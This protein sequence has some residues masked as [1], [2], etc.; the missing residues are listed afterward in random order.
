MC[1]YCSK[2]ETRH[3]E[4]ATIARIILNGQSQE[5]WSYEQQ[6]GNILRIILSHKQKGI[7][8]DHQLITSQPNTL[9]SYYS[10][11]DSITL[12]NNTLYKEWISPNLSTKNLL[13]LLPK[14]KIYTILS[15]AYDSPSAEH[16]G[17]NKTLARIRNRF[18]WPTY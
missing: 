13:I 12:I 17:I 14:H 8:P 3:N 6:Q 7:K 5:N 11:W 9:R 2:I 10:I 16:F 15:E 4:H 1:N 18:Y